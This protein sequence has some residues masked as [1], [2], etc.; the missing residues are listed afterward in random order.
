MADAVATSKAKF[1]ALRAAL[2]DTDAAQLRTQLRELC[3]AEC[4]VT[5]AQPM[6][7]VTGPDALFDTGYGPLLEAIPDL[8]RR[9]Y[10]L[11]GAVDRGEHW[12]GCGG[13]YTG[14]FDHQWL[15][16][17]PTRHLV[18]MR[19]IEFYRIE[20]DRI[21]TMRLL[22]DIPQ[23]MMQA[24]AWPMAPSLGVEIH[25]PGPATQD[26]IVP[27]PYDEVQS[28]ASMQLVLDMVDGLRK[29]ASGGHEAMQLE[30]FWHPNMTWYGPAGIGSNRRIAGFR[31]W[32]Q[33]PFLNAM[34]DRKTNTQQGE[35][36][37]FFGDGNYVAFCGWPAMYATVSGDGWMGIAPSDRKIEF[38]SL[39]FW[40]CENGMLRENWVLID[41]LDVYD[42]LGVDVL[43]RMREITV[44][45]QTS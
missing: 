15:G 27:A 40:R 43:A 29:Y 19:Y 24:N 28:A 41:L 5:L 16:I 33:V 13:Y 1:G 44:A 2:Y 3:S 8:E 6:G 30:R 37:C 35:Y 26:G 31:N 17:P 22:W 10:I 25:V 38:C 32:H 42:Q 12:I 11:V 9:D 23:L 18:T 4:D 34:P 20:E 7:K 36:D 14:V 45:R 21:V 39:D